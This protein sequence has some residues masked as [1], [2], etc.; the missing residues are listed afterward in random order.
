M[1]KNAFED[2]V[3]VLKDSLALIAV[4]PLQKR[5][6]NYSANF[7]DLGISVLLNME[8]ENNLHVDLSLFNGLKNILTNG[9]YPYPRTNRSIGLGLSV[10]YYFNKN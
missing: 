1:T 7:I 8:F 2:G 4:N 10:G 9:F 5:L 6:T 3:P